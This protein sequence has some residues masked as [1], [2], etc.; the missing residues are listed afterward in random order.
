MTPPGAVL[1]RIGVDIGG[2]FTD[3]ILIDEATGQTWIK[4][5]PST[6]KD[7]SIGFLDATERLLAD[8]NIA[9]NAVSYIVHGTTVVTNAIIEATGARTGFITTEGFRD[10]FEMQRQ[11]RPSL[12]DLMFDQPK[13]LVPRYLALEVP[14][15][16]DASGAVLRPLDE[17]AVRLAAR[18][19]KQ[20]GVEAIAVCFLHGYLNGAHERRAGQIIREEFP[21]VLLS[22]SSEVAPEIREYFRASTT[23]INASVG[24]V[25]RRYLQSI[26]E[27]LRARGIHA[28]LLVMQSHGGVLTAA[29]AAEKPVFLVESGPAAGVIAAAYLGDL[30][31]FQDIMSFDMGGTTAKMGLTQRG[32]PRVTKEY[33][34]G[35]RATAHLGIGRGSGYPITTPV[36]DLVEIGA[37]G[38]SIAWVDSGNVLRVGPRSA[39]AEPGPACYGRGGTEPT[40]T[41]AQVVL[42]RLDPAYFLGGDMQLDADA[43][44]RAID[45]QCAYPLGLST[46][47]AANGIVEIANAAMVNALRLVS[48]QRGYDPRDFLLVAFGGGGPV[49]ANRL[50]AELQMPRTLIPPSPGVFS[51]MGLL[52]TDLK[53]DFAVTRMRRTDSVD[54]DELGE[55]FD[56]L[57]QRGR[58]ILVRE[59]VSPDDMVFTRQADIRYVGQSHALSVT[60]PEP[61]VNA[62]TLA[63]L[64][65]RF[66]DDHQ[67]AYGHSTLGEATEL[68]NIRLTATGRIR[69]PQLR[70]L[71]AGGA[72]QLPEPRTRRP[73]YFSE[74]SAF[75]DCPVYLRYG[76][77]SGARVSG[78][79]IVEEMDST[80][81]ISPGFGASVDEHGNLLI[82]PE[83]V[84]SMDEHTA[85]HGV[86]TGPS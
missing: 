51:A 45:E 11:I 27:R 64:I 8:A 4:K 3:A 50:A 20:D 6:P 80:T 77:G 19:L 49:H 37:G 57:L 74:A 39:G 32:L 15:R 44:A 10:I 38:G 55:I 25:A 52:V 42:G 30:L 60:M 65:E 63:A 40:V 13:P 68:V 83:R 18:R 16:L 66:H 9:G 24:P 2:T 48:I 35:A 31:G 85:T 69:K 26:Q 73:V 23:A 21:D 86:V 29:A 1:F 67:R 76:L 17:E 79:A 34:V 53:H 56:D 70:K 14:E 61:E 36:I 54:L 62:R 75:L 81:V 84:S 72:Q 41:D 59:D 78:P 82:A 28:E 71:P 5:V 7:P 22:L 12:Y 46:V 58:D 43:A 33:E 47:Q